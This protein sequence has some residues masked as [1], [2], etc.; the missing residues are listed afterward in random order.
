MATYHK[1]YPIINLMKAL[2]DRSL[3]ST[4]HVMALL[5][6]K[7]SPKIQQH[8]AEST[9]VNPP[10]IGGVMDSLAKENLVERNPDT[11]EW[12]LTGAGRHLVEP[13]VSHTNE[14][15]LHPHRFPDDIPETRLYQ[16]PEKG[17]RL[18]NGIVIGPAPGN[19]SWYMR[20]NC[21]CEVT[22]TE[23][24]MK[25]Q[26]G[27]SDPVKRRFKCGG[28]CAAVATRDMAFWN[29]SSLIDLP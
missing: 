3:Y 1:E 4:S 13:V 18:L 5:D 12:E 6:L 9:G 17:R 20:L 22:V 29:P 27:D 26:V 14:W 2:R 10:N 21:G 24:R 19:G 15:R 11:L 7:N 16:L 25:K 8:I 23:A 28:V